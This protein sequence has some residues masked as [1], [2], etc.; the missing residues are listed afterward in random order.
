MN[1]SNTKEQIKRFI[2]VY[3]PVTTCTLRCHYCYITQHR[4]FD[5]E[6]PKFKYTP[7]Q[8]RKALSQKR[9]GGV[10]L[11][12][13]CGGG[14]TLLPPEMPA[15]IRTLLEEGH[16]VMVVT[17]ATISQRFEELAQL[18]KELLCRLFFKFSYHYLELKK[19][20]LLDR[21]FNNIRKMRDAGAS[22][23]LELTPSDEAIPYIDEIKQTAIDNVGAPCHVTVGRDE[24]NPKYLP[25]L[26]NMSREEYQK[27]WNIFQSEFFNYKLSVFGTKRHE[28]CY[29]GDWSFYLNI[30]SGIMTQCYCSYKS[31]N[32][33]ENPDEPIPFIPIGNNCSEHHCYNAHAFLTLGNIPELPAPTYATLRNRVCLDGSEWLKPEMK[34]FMSTKLFESNKEYTDDQKARINSEIRRAKMANKVTN[35]TRRIVKEA[36]RKLHIKQ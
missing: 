27:T 10:C 30:G 35:G 6:L 36:A 19:R 3:V 31:H 9:L 1:T 26:T 2:D 15:Y 24:R 28:F 33:I 34:A 18:P 32:I 7:E 20:N 14:E 5:N 11:I 13:L 29:A 16:Y 23:T 25:I 17:N 8:I 12:N 4:L 22:F 21:F